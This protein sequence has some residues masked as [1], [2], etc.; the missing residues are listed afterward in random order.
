MSLTV[1]L[2][3]LRKLR[4]LAFDQP[5]N[6]FALRAFGNAGVLERRLVGGR[7]S[8]LADRSATRTSARRA[9]IV[10]SRLKSLPCRASKPT[11]PKVVLHRTNKIL[12]LKTEGAQV[13]G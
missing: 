13:P 1:S 5:A 9:S 2:S 8:D 4:A 12:A 11:K 7:S 3:G 6:G 10:R